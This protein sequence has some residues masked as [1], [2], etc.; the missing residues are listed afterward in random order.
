MMNIKGLSALLT[1]VLCLPGL[2]WGAEISARVDKHQITLEDSIFFSVTVEGG[3]T[4]VDTSMIKDFTVMPRGTSSSFQ[5]INGKTERKTTYQYLL[6]PRSQGNLTIPPVSA[7]VDGKTLKT[8]PIIIQV[9]ENVVDPAAVRSLFARAAMSEK[10]LFAGQQAVYTVKLFYSKRLAGLGFENR[11][12]FKGLHAKAFDSEKKYAL[13]ID[14]QPFN[15]IQVD[16]L[17]VPSVPGT[18]AIDPV[19]FI[20]RE[21]VQ[22]QQPRSFDSIFNDSF[23]STTTY[24]PV[25][26]VS[27]AVSFEVKPL[28]E[29]K[30]KAQFSGLVGEFKI[31][32]DV[33]KSQLNVGDS[34]TFTITISGAGNIMDASLPDDVLDALA[35]KVY[36]DNPVDDI[37]MAEAGYHGQRVF[38]KAL[39]PVSEGEYRIDPLELVYF[40]VAERGYKTAFTQPIQLSVAP[41][42]EGE[43]QQP[44]PQAVSETQPLK[45]EVK[46]LNRDIL[47]IKQGLDVLKDERPMSVLLFFICLGLPGGIFLLIKGISLFK[48]KERTDDKLMQDKARFHLKQAQKVSTRDESYLLHL[49][50]ALVATILAKGNRKGESLTAMEARQILEASDVKEDITEKSLNLMRVIES[51][52]FGGRKIDEHGANTLFADLKKIIKVLGCFFVA[53]LIFL[54]APD[55]SYADVTTDFT[56][57]MNYYRAEKFERSAQYFEKVANAPIRN[58][59]LYYNIGNAWL[60]A[61]DLGKAVLWYE[62]AKLIAPNDP[63]LVYNL[64]Y[65]GSLVKDKKE[66]TIDYLDLIFFWDKLLRVRTIQYLAIAFSVLFF[67]W[68]ATRVLQQQKIFSGTGLLLT[69]LLLMGIGISAVSYYKQIYLKTAVVIA[70]ET[71][72]RSGSVA[73]ATPLF[74]LHAGTLVTVKD[75]RETAVKIEFSDDRIG[76]V[77]IGDVAIVQDIE[78]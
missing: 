14:G 39:V 57:A 26:V 15:V 6:T 19:S 31:H 54:S 13:N 61:G 66:S 49:Y 1:I 20:A 7:D 38:K 12:D 59:H 43:V 34:A 44:F 56:Q 50:T 47:D 32:A 77:S 53:G 74:N 55:V 8:P 68:A 67:G 48:R 33:D 62:R 42:S 63:D 28:P 45:T 65:A 4:Q 72:V 71:V 2:A 9:L 30:G 78:N 64:K 51:V 35:F 37:T 52:R 10:T 40:D 58:A 29:Y 23:F 24:K 60:K 21:R 18:Y 17:V 70:P 11:P 25:R 22:A 46:I 76:W 5:S 27:N 3:K 73:A 41:S 16:F 75:Q 36:D 69:V